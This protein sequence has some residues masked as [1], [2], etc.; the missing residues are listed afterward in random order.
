MMLDDVGLNLRVWD[1]NLAS[2]MFLFVSIAMWSL[3]SRA[4][5]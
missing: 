5:S 1:I 3:V 2:I 4:E